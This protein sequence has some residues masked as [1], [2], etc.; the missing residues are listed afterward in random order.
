MAQSITIKIAGKD[1][2]LVATTPDRERQMRLAAE[3][4]NSMLSRYDEKFPEKALI[5][6]LAFV[7]LNQAVGKIAIREESAKCAGEV[8]SLEGELDSY[9]KGKEIN[10]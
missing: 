5:D 10:R 2:P 3:D 9:L 4:V 1:Y 6:K 8:Q 7:A